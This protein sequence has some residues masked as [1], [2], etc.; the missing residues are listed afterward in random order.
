M[1]WIEPTWL[2]TWLGPFGEFPSFSP[3]LR[4]IKTATLDES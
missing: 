4:V 2:G 3:T 1:S